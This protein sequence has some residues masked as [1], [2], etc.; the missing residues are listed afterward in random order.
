MSSL[1]SHSNMCRCGALSMEWVDENTMNSV[2]L[3]SSLDNCEQI[4][5]HASRT[6][7]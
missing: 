3:G 1:V 5:S 7:G 6:R 4:A 2:I